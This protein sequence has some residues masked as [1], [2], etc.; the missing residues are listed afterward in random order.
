MKLLEDHNNE[1]ADWFFNRAIQ[2]EKE[3]TAQ[4]KRQEDIFEEKEK[5][6]KARNRRKRRHK[7]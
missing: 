3:R 7:R 1:I 4:L 5:R 6:R 2:V